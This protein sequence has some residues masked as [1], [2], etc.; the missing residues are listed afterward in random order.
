M[1][2]KS[3]Q[4]AFCLISFFMMTKAV[5]AQTVTV[6]AVPQAY[7]ALEKIKR[8]APFYFRTYYGTFEELFAR[9]NSAD[10]KN[11]CSLVISDEEKIPVLLIEAGKTTYSNYKA[12]VK[13]PLI[14]WSADEK[15]FEEDIKVIKKKR[16]KSLA[17]PKQ[18]LSCVG[19]TA[20]QV[21]KRKSFPTEYLKNRIYRADHEFHAYSLVSSGNVQAGFMT[22]PVIMRNGKPTGSY[23]LVPDEYYD[24]IQYYIVNLSL[25]DRKSGAV[26]DYI[27]T[28]KNALSCFF[29]AGF[30]DLSHINHEQK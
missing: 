6:C 23:W 30:C 2:K 12:F 5:I 11:Y 13:A 15:L 14:L 25:E 18:N 10:K 17:L 7:S 16:L 24:Q 29:D 22:K 9:I 1:R 26:Y 3:F 21:V 27:S 4:I 19:F 8:T 28:D 20:G